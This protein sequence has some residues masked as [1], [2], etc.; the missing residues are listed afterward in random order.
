M[1]AVV[2]SPPAPPE[3]DQR[4]PAL[5]ALVVA[6]SA[7][8]GILTRT[9][10]TD[11]TTIRLLTAQVGT[12]AADTTAKGARLKAIE[13]LNQQITKDLAKATTCH[14]VLGV[15]CPTRGEAY[16]GG[17]GTVLAILLAVKR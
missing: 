8:L 7:A 1:K 17:A 9:V 4:V 6:D 13:S 3:P 11:S 12:L 10:T 15:P 14:I 16:L 5:Q 2:L